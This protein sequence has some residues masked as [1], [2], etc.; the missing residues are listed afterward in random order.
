MGL[1]LNAGFFSGSNR[2]NYAHEMPSEFIA[3]RNRLAVAN[4]HGVDLRT[5]ALQF[6]NSR[7]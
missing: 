7:M 2:Y 6:A 3:K 4:D 5:A 1:N